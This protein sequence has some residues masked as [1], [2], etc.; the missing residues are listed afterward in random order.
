[1]MDK[2]LS[3]FNGG[4]DCARMGLVYM[5]VCIYIYRYVCFILFIYIF[6]GGIEDI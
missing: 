4:L 2:A 6:G 5:Y 3:R 1:M